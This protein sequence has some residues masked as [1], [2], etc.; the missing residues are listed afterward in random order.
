MI[1]DSVLWSQYA[2]AAFSLLSS[3]LVTWMS[4]TNP[5]LEITSE[6]F[7]LKKAA[8]N[9]GLGAGRQDL[10][11]LDPDLDLIMSA[12]ATWWVFKV[13]KTDGVNRYCRYMTL[14]NRDVC[15]YPPFDHQLH[16]VIIEMRGDHKKY[17]A[18]YFDCDLDT[19]GIMLRDKV[20][21]F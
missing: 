15:P 1:W 18:D 6:S 3:A 21:D 4:E 10:P 11:E 2:R 5:K 9:T 13:L 16:M 12:R 7:A 8:Y 19:V 17:L 20:A 14:A